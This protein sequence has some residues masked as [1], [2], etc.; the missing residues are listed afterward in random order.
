M[1]TGF[2]SLKVFKDAYAVAMEIYELSKSFPNHELYSLTDQIRR[3]SRS[4][5]A[6]IAEAYRKRRYP[7]AFTNK[8]TDADGECSETLVWLKFSFDC[9]YLDQA[10]FEGL[11][12]KAE[13]I[14]KTLG[15]MAD[16]PEKFLP[17]QFKK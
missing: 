13:E 8:I 10:S 16:H 9:R 3:S 15:F 1:E 6:N 7:A 2:T 4:V 11:Y 12:Q 14:G 5:C 17:K